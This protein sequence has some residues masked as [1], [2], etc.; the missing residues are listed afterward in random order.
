MDG[1]LQIPVASIL[2]ATNQYLT[3]S[4]GFPSQ[5]TTH[6][7]VDHPT[8]ERSPDLGLSTHGL[9]ALAALL[10]L[11]NSRPTLAMINNTTIPRTMGSF[12]R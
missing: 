7:L 1:L 11:Y 6:T 9:T 8:P 10:H 3:Y 5:R 4:S 2:G 12:R